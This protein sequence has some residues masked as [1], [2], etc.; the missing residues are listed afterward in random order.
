MREILREC[1]L[2]VNTEVHRETVRGAVEFDVYGQEEIEGR[3]YSVAC[4]CKH[5]R[6]RIPQS[7]VHAFRTVVG[8]MGVNV[9]YVISIAGFQRGAIQAA[10]H[11]NVKLRTW[12]EFQGEF[13]RSWYLKF[14]SP[15]I[16]EELDPLLTYTEPL[17]PA[18][19]GQLAEED[20]ERYLALREKYEA[21]GL[22][23]MSL[24]PLYRM[25]QR[26][27]QIPTLPIVEHIPKDSP[28]R[29][30]V[31]T[32]ILTARGYRELYDSAVAFGGVAIAAFRAIRAT[33]VQ[34]GLGHD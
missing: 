9:G 23:V 8:D 16:A 11:T 15:G 30:E 27:P 3:I 10:E 2:E 19:F 6:A 29:R 21:F 5:W 13:E 26:D 25:L 12:E 1:G 14:F 22:L 28:L 20:K 32:E 17:L 24:T 31:P 7:A 33:V 18:W 4:E 34:G